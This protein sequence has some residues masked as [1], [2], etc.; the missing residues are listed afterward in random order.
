MREENWEEALPILEGLSLAPNHV[1]VRTEA[2]ALLAQL[3]DCRSNYGEAFARM[4]ARANLL[5]PEAGS[6]RERAE[7]EEH[8]LG[9]LNRTLNREVVGRWAEGEREGRQPVLLS[10][11]PQSGTTLLMRMLDAH[12]E[13]AAADERE[14]LSGVVLPSLVEA[15]GDVPEALGYK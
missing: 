1:L 13:I 3:H 10:G 5:L 8:H 15:V 4:Q 14:L 9:S 6:Y 2:C 7:F 11:A 12:P